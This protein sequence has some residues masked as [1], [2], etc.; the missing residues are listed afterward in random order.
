[1]KPW[2]VYDFDFP[3]GSHPAVVVSN[4]VRCET[5]PHVVVL[6]CR[7]L[8]ARTRREAGALEVI[9]NSAD[10][11]DWATLCKCDLLYTVDRASLKNLR[12]IVSPV[13]RREIAR[14]MVQGLA[15]TG[16]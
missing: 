4:A 16:L 10:G 11:L 7:T 15:I 13:R 12:G 1:M 6:G 5:E 8:R 14:R 2:E 9:L 3:W